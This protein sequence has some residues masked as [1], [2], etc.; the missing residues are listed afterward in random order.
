LVAI[1][2]YIGYAVIYVGS[3]RDGVWAKSV[4]HDAEITEAGC[5]V[6]TEG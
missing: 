1:H 3:R 2:R 5:G 6:R 4:K